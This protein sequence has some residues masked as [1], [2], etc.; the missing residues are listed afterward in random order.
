MRKQREERRK[1]RT[2]DW[3]SFM[4][5]L[6]QVIDIMWEY[7]LTYVA[8]GNKGKGPSRDQKPREHQPKVTEGEGAVEEEKVVDDETNMLTGLTGMPLTED[9]L[10]FAGL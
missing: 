2:G 9:E 5:S 6:A 7:N 8:G 1:K 3:K 10:L 4:G